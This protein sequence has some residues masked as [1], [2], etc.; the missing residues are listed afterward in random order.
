LDPLADRDFTFQFPVGCGIEDVVVKRLRLTL[1][2]GRKRRITI[3]ADPTGNPKAVNDLL[4]KLN[5][6]PYYVT[7]AD[8]KVT[9]A[10]TP[11]MRSRAR[12]FTISYP[13]WCGL[14]H[15]GRDLIIRKML[16]DSGIEPIDPDME[17]SDNMV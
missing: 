4:D 16:A 12:T 17:A 10:P 2:S 7:Q 9:F 14:K 13:N 6:P 3:E 15:D 11:G 5:L 8:I 1:K